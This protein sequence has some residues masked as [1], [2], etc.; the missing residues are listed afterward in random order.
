MSSYPLITICIPNYN[1]ERFVEA[2]IKSI[3]SQTFSDF[4]VLFVDNCSTDD[5]VAI[6]NKLRDSRIEIHRN[7]EHLHVTKNFNRS[8][9]L[10]TRLEGSPYISMIHSDDVYDPRYLEVMKNYLDRFPDAAMA[11]CD[12]QTINEQGK[13]FKDF[14]FELKRK[15]VN[16]KGLSY[17]LLPPEQE[18]KKLLRADYIIC[19]SVFYRSSLFKD[20]GYFNESY[21]QVID[22]DFYLRVLLKRHKILYVGEKLYSYR[23]HGSYTSSNRKDLTKYNDYLNLFEAVVAQVS[24]VYPKINFSQKQAHQVIRNI[25]LWDIKNDLL[26]KNFILARQKLDFL[27]K[28][29]NGVST[30]MLLFIM[31][32][33]LHLKSIGGYLLDKLARFYLYFKTTVV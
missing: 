32:L 30:I 20:I 21:T 28:R 27:A 6:V 13:P 15:I 7:Q 26:E 17:V 3:L 16:P 10:A 1:G 33:L 24:E 18:I 11:H 25:L 9:Q 31:R 2:T 29:M 14:K 4:K 19:P 5:S 12:F 23:L 22:W 8:L